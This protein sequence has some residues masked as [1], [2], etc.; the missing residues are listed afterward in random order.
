MAEEILRFAL[1]KEVIRRKHR[2]KRKLN[3]GVAGAHEGDEDEDGEE[4]DESDEEEEEEEEAPKRMEM[5]KGK[6]KSPTPVPAK[7]KPVADHDPDVQM[8]DGDGA[9]P[10]GLD[11]GGVRPERW[12]IH[13]RLSCRIYS[14]FPSRR[15]RLFKERLAQLFRTTLVDEDQ[16]YLSTLL[17]MINQGLSNEEL[18]GTEE[19]TA[20]CEIMTND[21]ELMLS[22]GVVY[23]I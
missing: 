10:A 11:N 15:L 6:G 2:K 14:S 19:A 4:S 22:D 9:P 8:G 5:P 3:S 18:F 21:N 23:K 12:V 17:Q 1:F 16:M 20:I 7:P 13:L